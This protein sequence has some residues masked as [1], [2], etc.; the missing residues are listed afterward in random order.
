MAALEL[1]NKAGKQQKK[2]SF[3]ASR[4]G[5]FDCLGFMHIERGFK[6]NL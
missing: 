4:V 6:K 3:K 1:G 5:L 2:Q